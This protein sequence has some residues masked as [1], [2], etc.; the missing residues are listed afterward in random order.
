MLG[1]KAHIIGIVFLK[2]KK[3]PAMPA[4]EYEVITY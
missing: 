2:A 1:F 3:T 4:L